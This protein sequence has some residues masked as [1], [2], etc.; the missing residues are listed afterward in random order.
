[1]QFCAKRLFRVVK[2]EFIWMAPVSPGSF[3]KSFEYWN[4]YQL[5]VLREKKC[6][7]RVD[8]FMLS[9]LAFHAL[10]AFIQAYGTLTVILLF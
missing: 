10:L 9:S 8:Y 7:W 6:S 4:I 2:V 3:H 5:R 1:M